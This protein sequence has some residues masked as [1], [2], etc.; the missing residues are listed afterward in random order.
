[1]EQTEQ[2]IAQLRQE[3]EVRVEQKQLTL[4]NPQ[5]EVVKG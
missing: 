4:V 3:A 2:N 1:M 5:P